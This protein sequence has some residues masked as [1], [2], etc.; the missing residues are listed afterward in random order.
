MNDR[1]LKELLEKKGTPLY[2][3]DAGQLRRRVQ[4]LRQALPSRVRLCYAV[5]ANTFILKEMG[6]LVDR[7]EICSPGELEICRKLRLPSEK[8][9]ISGVY[10]E[11]SLMRRLISQGEDAGV[12]TVESMTQFSILHEAAAKAKKKL[13]VLLRLTSGN[14]FGLDEAEIRGI[15]AAHG[16]SAYLDIRGIQYFS[17]TQKS[18]IKRLK[19][20]LAAVDLFL[21][22]LYDQYGYQAKELEFGPGFPVSYFQGEPFA[23]ASF[24]EQFSQLLEGMKFS[25]AITLELGRSIAASCGKY[26]TKVVDQK[27]NHSENYAIVD[28]G[29]H[30]LVYFG[31]FMA[32]KHP[33][34]RHIPSHTAAE[35]REGEEEWN[36]CGSLCTVN[37]ILV[38]KIPLKNLQ[39]GDILQFE[40]TG[41][42]CITEGI[43]LFLS[44][45]LPEVVLITEDGAALTLRERVQTEV[46][47]TPS[48]E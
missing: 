15:L 20:E 34:V 17:G 31:Q 14:Q 47:N 39:I 43:S 8:F 38:K 35:A 42:Y 25:G 10:K 45:D 40:N 32:M 7:F 3:F 6:G 11:P 19:R 29:M 1:Q 4:T 21:E 37:D 33:Y 28:G 9:V 48:Y 18:S 46:L 26:F 5:K 36:I 13:P 30:Q 22:T 41:A 16:D 12:Y 2:L 27:R 44:R 23:E 24:L